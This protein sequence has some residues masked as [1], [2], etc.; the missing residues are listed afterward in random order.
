MVWT[1]PLNSLRLV[2]SRTRIIF[3]D[4]TQFPYHVILVATTQLIQP[5]SQCW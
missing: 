3:L 2:T 4:D 1:I 5:N